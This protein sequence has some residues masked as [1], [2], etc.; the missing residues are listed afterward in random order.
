MRRGGGWRDLDAGEDVD[1]GDELGAPHHRPQ[2]AVGRHG[3]GGPA[4][5]CRRNGTAEQPPLT[6]VDGG[7]LWNTGVFGVHGTHRI[8]ARG[9]PVGWRGGGLARPPGR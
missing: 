2:A 3:G 4:Q 9:N 5:R 6:D 7:I 8:G 1:E